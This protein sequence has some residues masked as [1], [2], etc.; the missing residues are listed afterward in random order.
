MNILKSAVLNVFDILPIKFKNSLLHLS[1]NVARPEFDRFSHLYAYAPSM[2]MG[3]ISLTRRGLNPATVIDVGAFEGN[4]S[5][6]V[7]RVWPNS[8]IVM[9]EPN[10]KKTVLVSA[11]SK[12]IEATLFHDLLGASDGTQVIFTVMESGSSIMEE[13]SP[14]ERTKEMRELRRLD[15]VIQSVNGKA[16]L[17]IDAQGY[18]LEILK[19]AEKLLPSVDAILLE[20]AV[21]QINEGAPILHEVVAFM[22]S[23]DFVACEILEI[24]RRPLDQAL[25]QFDI[26]FVREDSVLLADKRHFSTTDTPANG[27]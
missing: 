1:F 14:L 13:N 17:K 9:F 16:F 2:E 15:T 24:H 4:W 18:E 5:R 10:S 20:V 6:M 3:L 7:R 22:K 27:V 19:G 23:I 26:L 25:N 11:A 21:I 8:Q 12:E